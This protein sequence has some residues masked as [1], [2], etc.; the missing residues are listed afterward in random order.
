L[1]TTNRGRDVGHSIVESD[2]VV[3]VGP[4]RRDTLAAIVASGP[5]ELRIVGNEHPALAGRYD[6][7]AEEAERRD[8][9]KR[10]DRPSLVQ[11]AVGFGGVLHNPQTMSLGDLEDRVRVG[12]MSV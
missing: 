6:L 5:G 1:S 12:W 7:V 4:G 10:S 9:G 3:P 2:D 8:I 11:G